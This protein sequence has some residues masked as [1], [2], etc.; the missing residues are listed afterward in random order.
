MSEI[1]KEMNI[2][3]KESPTESGYILEKNKMLNYFL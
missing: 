3:E 1:D 2:D